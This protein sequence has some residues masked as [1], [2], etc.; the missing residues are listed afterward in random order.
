MLAKAI[1][2][3]S[4][5]TFIN[6]KL[7]TI[8]SKW[9]G[10]AEKFV[11][12]LF[13]LAHKLQPAI[14]FIDEVDSCLSKRN[15]KDHAIDTRMK[16]E[17][18]ML[19]DGLI[20][21]Q[22]AR[23]MVLAATNRPSELDEAVLGRLPQTFEVGLP[24]HRGRVDILKV[25]LKGEKVESLIDIDYIAGLCDGYSGSDL[26]ELCKQAAYFPIRDLL[27]AE[28]SGLGSSEPRPLS[29]LDLEEAFA[30]KQKTKRQGY[31]KALGTNSFEDA[32]AQDVI[33]P[34]KIEVEFDSIGGLE[35]IKKSLYE[36]II[37]PLRRPELFTQGKLL[38]PQK[39]VLLYGPPGTGKTML[40]KAIAKESGATFIN[41][42]LSTIVRKW[43][44]DAEKFVA[45]L[46]SLAH[47]LQPAILFI[48]EVD[49]CLSKRNAKDHA[50]DTRMKTE[51]MM[52]WD[53]LI[54][55]Q[56]ARVMVLAA[57]NRPSELDEAVLRRLP[58]TF[59]VGLPDHRGRVD[60][61][62]VILKG[63]KVESLIDIDYIAG[64]CDGYS[65]SDLFELCKQAAYFPIRDLLNAEKSGLGSSEPRPLS[66][67]D[68]EEAFAAKQKTKRQG[69]TKALGTNSFEDAIAQDVINPDKI[70]VEF[71]SI[72]G[73]ENIK[74]SLY[75]LIILPLRRPELFTQGKLLGPQKG[76]LLYGP[77]GTGKTMLAKAIAKES[78]ATFI[79]VKLS[80]I[81]RKWIGDAEKFVAALFSLAHKLQPAILFID[82]VDSCLSKRNAKDHAID[83]RMKT[84][85][86]MLWDGLITDQN[87]RVM[88][89][90]ATNRPSELDE[91]VL[92][93]LPQTFEVG[94]PD[95]RGRVDI[96]KVILK[97]EKVE[98][99]IDID[100]IAG[101]CDGYSGSDLFEL[102]KQAAY[103][104]IRDLLNAEKS[105]L[106]S[107]E[108][109]PL[110]QLDLEEAF[111]AKQKTKRQGY[112]KALGT[113]SFEDA[114]AQD[115]IN[116][117]KIEV[118]FDSIGGLENIKK[119]LYE[120][121]ILPLRRPEL[122]TQGKLLGPQKGV[123]LYGPPGTGKTMLAKAIAKESGATFINVKLSTIVRKWIGDAE[124]FVAA[125]FSLAH[126]LQ[127]AILFIDEVDSCLSKRNAKDHAIDTRMKTEF[128]MLWDG[129]ITDQNARVMVLAAT[130]RPSEL[131]EAVLRRLP[132][133]FEVG[134]PD[135]RGRVD[136]LKVILKGEK[137]ESLIDID[138]IAGL[139]DGYSGSDLFE[140]CKQAAYFP[141]RDL[142]NAEKSGLGS[143]EPRPLSQLDLEEAFAAKQKTKR[144]GYTKALGTNSFEDAIAQDVINPDKI[145]VEFDSI[146]GLE[147][148]KKSLYE[149]IIL[150][151]RRPELFTQGKLLGPQKGVLLYGPP[152]TGKTMLAK[153]IAKES[154]A[155]F[156]NVK[157]STIVRKWIGDAEKFV[158]ALF[159]LAH[160]LQPAIL[161]IDEVDS[162]LSKRN[163]KDHAIDTRM[164]TEF[165]MLWDGLITDQNA[166]V[167]VLAATNRPSELDEAV[168]RRLPQTFEVGLPDHRGRVDILK[169]ILKGEKVESLIDIDYIAGLCDG[170]SGSDLFELCKQAAYFPIRDLLNAE[171]SGLGSS[172]PR[173]LSQ[174]DLEEA[175][176]AK[177][178]TKRQGYTKALG[179]NSFEDAIAQDVINPDKI[180]V[181]FDSIGGLENIKKSLYELIILPLRR[182][183][184]FTQGKLLGPQKGVLLYG[185]PGTGKTMLAKAIAKESGATFINVKLSTIVSKWI[186]VAEKHV[187]ALFSMAHKLQPAIIFIDE[188]DSCLKKRNSKEHAIDTRMKTEFMTLWDGLITDQNARVMVLAATNRPSELDEA[189]LRRLP[190]TFEVGLPDHMGR[191][192]ILKVILK[193]EKVESLIDIDHIA[194]LCDGYSGSDLFEL[195]KQAAYFSIRDLL[196]DEKSGL[197]SLEPRPLSQKD[198]EEAV[199]AKR[200]AK[201]VHS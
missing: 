173:P 163:A 150:P 120:L 53:G 43:I 185:P 104:P 29:Q 118:E 111:A 90:A 28:K 80:T 1:A 14:L 33:N 160:K 51:F 125:L 116:P 167:M 177:Q 7:S 2:K 188:V 145:E 124:K 172:E 108:P 86:M 189:V 110:S 45:A 54:T 200:K 92:R 140:L 20:T 81:V 22:N 148:I 4:G 121:I 115:V 52:L 192:N 74:K 76:V 72:G 183:E 98:S 8:V 131:D 119:S 105:G 70:E 41:V 67:L 161:F 63:E 68:L 11:A 89:L 159:S 174:L 199:A 128:M 194:S 146:G 16:T 101:L 95:H 23:V 127:P 154:G 30:A 155:T 62:K 100:Y 71:D 138:Y 31:T 186:G 170:Y 164:K 181:E 57:T 93:R 15:A 60:I 134:L 178:K 102:C 3:E 5:A 133:T 13:S 58:Q 151:L 99:L 49:S 142:L 35:N 158:A 84:E 40:A 175:F 197:E 114:I 179:T 32:I 123:L 141:I 176:A 78:G 18:M 156:I 12:A 87:A 195:C 106:G 66:Q 88:V 59:E 65:G 42:K 187:A 50:I 143:S 152:G 171:K 10:D 144:Q 36:L 130:N 97:G 169:V 64:L 122:F 147:N 44:G 91:A 69:Y 107:S 96:L 38:G 6:V 26:F 198:L 129:L 136:I 19:W 61:L 34:D 113:N 117:D 85:F 9:I 75:E 21:D 46:F 48:D 94:L 39:G 157:L 55:D 165:M 25:I 137:V 182:P 201:V 56:N 79:N 168:L 24:D 47:K 77:P 180:E 132:Q 112:T 135:H 139:C 103:F 126:K 27:N 149:L 17:F 82:E 83:T 190:Q 153:A 184:L 37:L 73:L 193:G 109:R 196:N 162:C 191:V 166:R